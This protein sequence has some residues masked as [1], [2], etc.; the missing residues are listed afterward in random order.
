MNDPRV[1]ANNQ[2][3]NPP[4]GD[5]TLDDLFAEPQPTTATSVPFQPPATTP[6]ETYAYTYRTREETEKGIR[7]KDA[8]IAQLRQENDSLKAQPGPVSVNAPQP[9]RFIDK[10][11]HAVQEAEAGRPEV[12]ERVMED[13]FMERMAPAA[14]ILMENAKE[15]AVRKLET[16]NPGIRSFIGSDAYNAYLA[17]RP[18]LKRA[19][20]AAETNINYVPDLTQIYQI[21]HEASLGRRVPQA[22]PPAETQ[23]PTPRPTLTPSTPQP[24]AVT[25]APD[26]RTKEGRDALIREYEQRG[27]AGAKVISF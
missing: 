12:Y 10:V 2:Q 25:P 27:I 19:V 18:V 1:P 17:E 20:E 4:S 23:T 21:A 15:I 14:A 26:L 9:T 13:F 3:W 16:S 5:L 6:A 8:Y 7:D 11:K 24:P 22:A